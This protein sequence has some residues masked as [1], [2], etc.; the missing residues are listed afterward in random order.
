MKVDKLIQAAIITFVLSVFTGVNWSSSS[1]ISSETNFN[2][3][4]VLNLNQVQK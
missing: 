3:E 2:N 4:I 1:Q